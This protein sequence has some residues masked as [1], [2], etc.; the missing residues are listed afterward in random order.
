MTTYTETKSNLDDIAGKS[1]SLKR[2]ND[3]LIVA[4]Q[5]VQSGLQLLQS[6]Y[7]AFAAQLNIDAAAN[8]G[9]P[10]WD[11]ALAEKDLLVAEFVAEKVRADAIV[12]ALT[13]L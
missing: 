1:S 5:A 8:A 11:A 4:A 13:G 3:N 12:L 9:D 10:A 7:A 6:D 2:R